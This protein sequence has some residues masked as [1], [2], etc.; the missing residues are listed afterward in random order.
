MRGCRV[1][2]NIREISFVQDLALVIV[3][4][5][6]IFYFLFYAYVVRSRGS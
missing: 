3:I 5:F 6:R 2:L 4:E 1:S